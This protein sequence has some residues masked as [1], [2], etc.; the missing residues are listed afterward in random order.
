M[1]AVTLVAWMVDLTVVYLAAHLA[2]Q[3]DNLLAVMMVE[4]TVVHLAY[5]LDNLLAVMMVDYL[6]VHLAALMV[7]MSVVLMDV[8]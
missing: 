8:Q 4:P 3:L 5:Q 6:V 7:V 1:T 2:Y